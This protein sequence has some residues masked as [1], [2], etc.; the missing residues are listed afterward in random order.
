MKRTT[1]SNLISLVLMVTILLCVLMSTAAAA[2]IQEPITKD[3]MI[4]ADVMRTTGNSSA[5]LGT[6]ITANGAKHDIKLD[7]EIVGSFVFNK[8]DS[9][10]EIVLAENVSVDVKWNCS[11]YYAAS[12][13][14]GKGT[15]KLPQ[16]LQDNGKTQSFNA[17]WITDVKW[18][19]DG[20]FDEPR[21]TI[22]TS[23][24]E[25]LDE[26]G[27][28]FSVDKIIYRI[29][30]SISDIS[31]I[32]EII[33][34][35][36]S[37]YLELENRNLEISSNWSIENPGLVVGSND[38]MI[39]VVM[40]NG[41]T[42]AESILV[43]NYN[44]ENMK[45]LDLDLDD[46]DGDGLPNWLEDVYGTDKN[47]P[48]TDGDGLTD[49]EEIFITFTNPLL[50]DSD[51]SG[52]SDGEKDF[53]GD[54][55]TNIQEIFYGTN[56]YNADTDGDG[57]SDYDE[58]FVYFTDPLNP[59]SDGDG[60]S[61]YDEIQL[62]LD[63]NNPMTDEITPDA[64][65]IFKQNTGESCMDASL[66]IENVAIP[67]I[68]VDTAGYIGSELFIS[69]SRSAA[70]SH[71]DAVQGKPIH[72]NASDRVKNGIVSFEN[73]SQ[74]RLSELIICKVADGSNDLIPL[75]TV[76]DENGYFSASYDG[77]GSY[78][79]VD[80][81][82]L[83]TNLGIDAEEVGSRSIAHLSSLYVGSYPNH[84]DE[85]GDEKDV[86]AAI[87]TDTIR[88]SSWVSGDI[89]EIRQEA[90]NAD[91]TI[92]FT[93]PTSLDIMAAVDAL[94]GTNVVFVVDTSNSMIPHR[95]QI[96]NEIISS[97]AGV[98]TT[99]N[100]VT[101]VIGE[102]NGLGYRY[103]Y[104]DY[105]WFNQASAP[106]IVPQIFNLMAWGGGGIDDDFGKP[107]EAI[108][109]ANNAML[110]YGYY[111]YSSHIVLITDEDFKQDLS[112]NDPYFIIDLM[113]Q[114]EIAISA[115]TTQNM[116][117]AYKEFLAT[118]GV[119]GNIYGDENGN[120]AGKLV[121]LFHSAIEVEPS[122]G[123]WVMLNDMR[124][125]KLDRYPYRVD[126]FFVDTD[127][128]GL[129]DSEELNTQFIKKDITAFINHALGGISSVESY[130]IPVYDYT[131]D[132]TLIDSDGDGLTDYEE[133]YVTFTN[134]LIFDALEILYSDDVNV[135][136]FTGDLHAYS[137]AVNSNASGREDLFPH[138]DRTFTRTAER[139]GGTLTGSYYIDATESGAYKLTIEISEDKLKD[140]LSVDLI[141]VYTIVKRSFW[142]GG[143]T[144]EVTIKDDDGNNF[145][146]GVRS[147]DG[148]SN[149]YELR[150]HVKKGER[151]Y[152]DVESKPILS[153][154]KVKME[155]R[156]E[157]NFD[158]AE[159]KAYVDRYGVTRQAGGRWTNDLFIPY[160]PDIGYIE[161]ET[162]A[163][164]E[165]LTPVGA[166][167]LYEV[168][169]GIRNKDKEFKK[170]WQIAFEK[171][172]EEIRG[173]ILSIVQSALGLGFLVDVS[174]STLI[175]IGNIAQ[176][177]H[178]EGER[179]K[180]LR[181]INEVTKKQAD[182][183]RENGVKVITTY[184]KWYI[185]GNL[186]YLIYADTFEEWQ[187]N[188]LPCKLFP[189][190]GV[191]GEKG[192]FE[193]Y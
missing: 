117:G 38:I 155:F 129:L 87:F 183:K 175:S 192:A 35:N 150:F 51:G 109:I 52:I 80:V 104:G 123:A 126:Y 73:D 76:F 184:K 106:Q 176:N 95:N 85:T 178:N 162:V 8:N 16:L 157:Y 101:F 190:C 127:G 9:Y 68:T 71:N 130:Y 89:E 29:T 36:Y 125:V 3:G 165:Y 31:E 111:G 58:I 32:S 84:E 182:G 10:I 119:V 97:L 141:R 90:S 137:L 24:F 27:S 46:N 42:L 67:H 158:T 15:Y 57:L 174:T 181:N 65:R 169:I 163:S 142:E 110:D 133:I 20:D 5:Y 148:K 25:P 172:E 12:T 60:L 64:E 82:E 135:H 134:P 99:G 122:D 43:I 156:L 26:I 53:D 17:I 146:E 48:D 2:T 1:Y 63:P 23:E 93:E 170:N 61:D 177:T 6:K 164:I 120:M 108:T 171:G 77:I 49:Y 140:V 70:L 131:S 19:E 145:L 88:K 54:G 152:I 160:F 102:Y 7:G 79:L 55:L 161:F 34:S 179:V 33:Y 92:T 100:P 96:M 72:I 114:N 21:I 147:S 191:K 168:L 189:L 62:G 151:Y 107:A 14:D 22:D 113:P 154:D 18:I 86:D 91:N 98:I 138:F 180:M 56:P 37:G 39:T 128:D 186:P 30:G 139:A 144:K 116:I 75:V 66:F 78:V 159:S 112:N 118:G 105:F 143:G 74:R 28:V 83:L 11:K 50:W 45:R 136:T 13:L 149:H 44:E 166:E 185:M 132:P 103:F 4:Y 153:F 41:T 115:F 187:D 121:S 94:M 59:D 81:R 193:L 188:L 167:I 124:R 40:T 47:N 69:V 173:L